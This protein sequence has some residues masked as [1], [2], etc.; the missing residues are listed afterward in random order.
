MIRWLIP[1]ILV[2]LSVSAA[3]YVNVH[4]WTLY[5]GDAES[6]LDIARRVIDSRTPGYDQLGTSWLPLPHVL[7]LPFVGNDRLWRSGLAGVIPSAACFV[8]AGLFLFGSARRAFGSLTAAVTA[9]VCFATNPNLLYLQATPMTEPL[10]FAAVLGLLYCTVAFRDRASLALAAWAGLASLAASLTRYEG[11]FLIPFVTAFFLAG[12]GRLNLR[13][14]ILFGAIASLAPLYWLVH[15]WWYFGDALDFYRGPYSARA[16]QGGHP[17]PG[18]HDWAKAWLYYRTAAESTAGRGIVIAGLVGC[19][20]ALWKRQWWPVLL[21]ALLPAFYLWSMHSSSGTPIFVPT[22]WPFTYYN[23]RYGLEALPFLALGAGAAVLWGPVRMR[24]FLAA[25]AIL[26]SLS[27]WIANPR[28][29]AVLCW[30]ESEV[31]SKARRAWTHETAQFLVA[32]YRGTGIFSTLGDM[33]GVFREAGIP[34]REVLQEG[35]E[36]AWLAAVARPDLFLYDQW[37][38]AIDDDSVSKASAGYPVIETIS[39]KGARPIYIRK[40]KSYDD[41]IH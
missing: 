18:L 15:N 36:P 1:A 4:G 17:Y 19:V 2:A 30:K 37:A 23:T 27:P 35:N 29:E 11:W 24:P 21:L 31:N 22:L 39:V 10:F 8:V 13:A 5:Y 28:P 12:G 40:R 6:H 16:I 25:V 14:A 41:S 38:I 3:A 7:M 33:G 34:F 20:A 9:L 32:H 26:L